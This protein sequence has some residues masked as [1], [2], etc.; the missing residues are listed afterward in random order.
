MQG[1]Q[2]LHKAPPPFPTNVYWPYEILAVCRNNLWPVV[3]MELGQE[4]RLKQPVAKAITNREQ[5]GP[6][7]A[8]G[9]GSR[10]GHQCNET[11]LTGNPSSRRVGA[12]LGCKPL[13]PRQEANG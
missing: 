13:P 2:G 9:H 12:S 10:Q 7:V 6:I 1:L 11:S 8:G 4:G 3:R 5:R